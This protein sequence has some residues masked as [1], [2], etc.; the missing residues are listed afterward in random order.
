VARHWK[1]NSIP[2]DPVTQSNTRGRISF[3]TSGQDSRTSQMFINSVDNT[4]LDGMGFAPIGSVVRGM[5]VVDQIYAGYGEKPDQHQ[6]QL[7]GNKF[8]KKKYPRLSYIEKVEFISSLDDD[9]TEL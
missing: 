6:I 3:A 2:D 5:D 4:N 9:A 7:E 8:L 1:E